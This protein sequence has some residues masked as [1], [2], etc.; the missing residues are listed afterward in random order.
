MLLTIPGTLPGLNELIDAART[1]RYKSASL[2]KSY[3]EMIAYLAKIH[4]IPPME[5]VNL[6]ITWIEPSRR[7][8]KDNIIGGGMKP[9]MDGLVQAGVIKNDGWKEVGD[10]VHIFQVDAKNPRVEVD[11]RETKEAAHD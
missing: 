4:K 9:I 7:R 10:M 11:I 2:K 6:H 8:D 5:R 1:N 3:T